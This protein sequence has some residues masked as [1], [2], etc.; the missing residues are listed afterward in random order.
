MNPTTAA[1]WFKA[2]AMQGNHVAQ[3]NLAFTY[4][5][6]G[7]SLDELVSAYAWVWLAASELHAPSRSLLD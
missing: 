6:S 2:A 5:A 3:F 1:K 7:V 4:F